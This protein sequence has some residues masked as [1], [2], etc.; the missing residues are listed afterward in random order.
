MQRAGFPRLRRPESAE[1]GFQKSLCECSMTHKDVAAARVC[2][3]SANFSS[4]S[5]WLVWS[6]RIY[7]CATINFALKGNK[8]LLWSGGRRGSAVSSERRGWLLPA[9]REGT[10]MVCLASLGIWGCQGPVSPGTAGGVI[11][12]ACAQ[13]THGFPSTPA[14]PYSTPLYSHSP[15]FPNFLVK[16]Y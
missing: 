13:Q 1:P 15:L 10:G 12:T 6:P 16:P 7:S 11:P 4:R 3:P 8:L 5:H 9:A 14:P 2:F